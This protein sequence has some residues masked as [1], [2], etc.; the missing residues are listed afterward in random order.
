M[1]ALTPEFLFDMESNMQVITSREYERLVANL[2]WR[3]LAKERPSQS[4]KERL[5]WML[6]T[7]RIQRVDSGSIEFEDVLSNTT[8]YEN[9]NAAGGLKMERNQIEDLDGN[10]IQ[11][12]QHWS[13]QMGAY[14][15]Y[16]PQ[17]MVAKAIRDNG[18]TYDGKALF[19]TDH[20]I[21]GKNTQAGTFANRFTSSA[22]GIYPGAC[23]IHDTGAGAVSLETAIRNIGKIIAYVASI[24]M[25][26]GEDPRF[27]KLGSIIH[28][29]ALTTRVQEICNAKL[30]AVAVGSAAGTSDI[31]GVVR[32]W[33]M[34]EPICAPELGS[35]FGG[36]DTSYYLTME[37]V[38][39]SELGAI[40]YINREAFS[41]LY[42]GHVESA[43]LA[44]KRELQWITNGRNTVGLG[45]PYL[46]FRGDAT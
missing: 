34:G 4:K 24:K 43:D 8:E 13:R 12:A 25:A 17:K 10:G 39:S 20:F 14:A 36:S 23:P 1:P 15:A 5:I 30:I 33:A 9:E 26:S 32:N 11:I 42:H 45:H 27:L 3:K 6:D 31:S 37:D 41:I 19:A 21:N 46:L 22:S 28:P 2:W 29:P 38:V 16:W 7:A 35:A 44:R 40:N 18:T